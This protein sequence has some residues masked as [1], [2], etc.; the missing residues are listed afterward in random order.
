MQLRDL[1]R[2]S[3]VLLVVLTSALVAL[4]WWGMARLESAFALA[5]DYYQLRE[6]VA[7][8]LRARVEDYLGSGDS[9]QLERARQQLETLDAGDLQRLPALRQPLQGEIDAL[10]ELLDL[11]ALAAGKLAGNP[12]ALLQQAEREAG[13]ALALLLQR[14]SAERDGDGDG[15]RYLQHGATLGA[16]LQRLAA[17]RERF[18][19]EGGAALRDNTLQ[20]WREA[21]DAS[22]ALQALPP[23]QLMKQSGGNEFEALLWAGREAVA[24]DQ[25]VEA[26]QQIAAALRRYP[27]ELERTGQLQQTVADTRSE[28][29]ERVQSLL[30]RVTAFESEIEA[31]RAAIER[32]VR[33]LALTLVLV[34]ALGGA[35]LLW[36]QRHL[37]AAIGELARHLGLLAAGDLRAPLRIRGRIRELV[38]LS[39]ATAALQR[40]LAEML[41]ALQCD[42]R[43]VADAGDAMQ[44]SAQALAAATAQQRQRALQASAAVEQMTA[45]TASM[46]GEA[47]A[48]R[49][50]AAQAGA[51]L[52]QG[53]DAVQRSAEAMGELGDEIAGVAQAL[54]QLQQET[55]QVVDFVSHIHGIAE[56]TNLLALNAAIEAARAGERGR[57]FAVVADEV[58][59]LA[60]RSSAATREIERLVDSIGASS[61]RLGAVLEQQ[62]GS[63]ARAVGESRTAESRYDTLAR[64]V[65]RIQHAIAIIAGQA[66]GQH[67]A[68]AGLAEFVYAVDEAAGH[69]A[70]LGD[71]S[72]ALSAELRAIGS[73]VANQLHRFRT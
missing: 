18:G 53:R 40:H 47:V 3:A 64:E 21:R 46:A 16:A 8:Q 13:D 33:W 15:L 57:G 41:G 45:A 10:R 23:L 54:L 26:R 11:R 35:V 70:Q 60:V 55:R 48:M 32:Q 25:S 9:Q 63:A 5:R 59:N 6:R 51:A 71:E 62:R 27:A 24:E 29:R 12:Q 17:A 19:G 34:L 20:L 58:R 43:R 4:L 68:S 7:G 1:N 31:Q 30:D 14:V 52:D 38:R 69:S 36:V 73:E 22:D 2:L 28:L 49:A 50:A 39:D 56:Q 37:A 67:Q 66:A 42:S 72:V 61:S 65:A 44:R